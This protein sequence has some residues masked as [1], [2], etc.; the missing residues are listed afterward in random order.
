R[1]ALPD[2]VGRDAAALEELRGR[3]G[4]RLMQ[5]RPRRVK[6]VACRDLVE[7]ITDYLDGALST[8]DR[9]RIDAHLENCPDCTRAVAQVR[10]VAEL[11][12]RLREE[13]VDRLDPDTRAALLD[14]FRADP[15]DPA[16]PSAG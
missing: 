13:D 5:E 10:A 14:A 9:R 15:A 16:D 6:P 1:R 7:Q 11:A 8:A 2:A 3:R 4:G 12:G